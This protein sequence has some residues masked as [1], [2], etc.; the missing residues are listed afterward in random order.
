LRVSTEQRND[1]LRVAALLRQHRLEWP[2]SSD[3]V[4]VP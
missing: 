2:I 1:R 4:P 3:R